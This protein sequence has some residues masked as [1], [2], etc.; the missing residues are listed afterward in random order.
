M[1]EISSGSSIDILGNRS[2]LFDY[3]E[4]EIFMEHAVGALVYK[5][6]GL[7]KNIAALLI[8]FDKFNSCIRDLHALL[9]A[10]DGAATNKKK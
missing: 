1:P 9:P 6:V 2:I 10:D 5:S 8:P 4:D 7:K 3:F